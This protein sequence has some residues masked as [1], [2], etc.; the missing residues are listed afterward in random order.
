MTLL[1]L[2]GLGLAWA[3]VFVPAALRAKQRTPVSSTESFQRGMGLLGAPMVRRGRYI[4]MP[5]SPDRLSRTTYQRSQ[6]R[7]RR[8]FTFL[9]AAAAIT[10]FGSVL[11]GGGLWTLNLLLDAALFV[12][13][14][15]LLAL[16]QQ[17][18]DSRQ[19]ADISARRAV[20]EVEFYEPVHATGGG[21]G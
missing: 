16:K 14:S 3:A 17:R 2:I 19:V 5:Q 18:L 13:V 11:F 15:L 9:L 12:Y 6:A 21:R 8:A 4:V 7:R 1:F 10:F 20:E